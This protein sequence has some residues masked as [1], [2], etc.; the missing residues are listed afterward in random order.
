MRKTGPGML[1]AAAFIG[2]GT[3]TTC[4][5]A[6]IEDGYTLLWALLVSVLATIVLQEMA[7]RLGLVTRAGLP[8]VIRNTLPSG[9]IRALVLGLILAAVVLG[10]AAYQ[11]G[12][13]AG[14]VLGLEALAGNSWAQL[15]PW[16]VGLLAF[17]LL[18]FG[19]YK[20][21]ERIFAL[22]VGLMSLSFLVA[23]VA[24][25]PAL[26]SLLEGLFVPRADG[27]ALWT[28]MALIGTT[29]V[30]YNLFLYA[31]LVIEKWEGALSLPAMRRDIILAVALGGIISMAI[32][33]TAAASGIEGIESVLDLASALEPVYGQA[34]RYGLGIGLFIAGISSA[35]TAPLA[36]AYVVRQ[37]F[38]WNPVQDRAR[39]RT[40]W[41][42]VLLFGVATLT[43]DFRPLEVIYFAQIAN[44][45][46]L[47]LLA[48]FLWW[49]VRKRKVMGAYVNSRTQDLAGAAVL[50]VVLVLAVK[51]FIAI[52][53]S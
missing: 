18:W 12:N 47:P 21:L 13:V 25:G 30:P 32:L 35:I 7:G 23:A 36:A 15:Y 34:A 51:S 24:L 17:L 22:L 45:L 42:A 49:S 48:G 2:P 43:L 27:E 44:A 9:V 6:G 26:P 14:A 53:S 37:C 1:I 38:A 46:L 5:R 4:L 41:A 20:V 11:A 29:V 28:V 8:G 3:V 33:V 39:F 50:L 19:T 10:N 16:V 40:V 52:L 31:S